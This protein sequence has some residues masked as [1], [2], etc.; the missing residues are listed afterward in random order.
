[1]QSPLFIGQLGSIRTS[2]Y[3]WQQE[4]PT[5]FLQN[6]AGVIFPILALSELASNILIK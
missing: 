1:M 4:T 3:C 5:D 2:V 6:W